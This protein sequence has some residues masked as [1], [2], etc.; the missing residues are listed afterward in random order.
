MAFEDAGRGGGRSLGWRWGRGRSREVRF[1][2]C[3][4]PGN[5]GGLHIS[6]AGNVIYNGGAVINN[7]AVEGGG[8]WNA[9]GEMTVDNVTINNN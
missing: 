3:A 8:L 9:S 5:G 7:S 2:R 1:R 6:G 4:A